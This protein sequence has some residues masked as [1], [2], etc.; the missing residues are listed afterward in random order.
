MKMKSHDFW[1][2]LNNTEVVVMPKSYIQT[3]GTTS[4][5]YHMVSELMDS[6]N[7]IR[8]REGTIKSQRPEI[9]TPT[10][11]E[12][13]M[14]EGFGDEAR[15]YMEWLRKHSQDVLILQYGFKIQKHDLNEHVVS[16]NVKEVLDVVKK[17]VLAKDDPFAGVILGVDDPWDVCLLKLMIDIIQKSAPMNFNDMKKRRLFDNVNGIPK[18]I[19]DEIE[20]GFRN[21]DRDPSKTNALMG[22]LKKHDV[23]EEYEDRFFELVRRRSG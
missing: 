12:D 13:A 2:A 7:R 23:F 20:T 22:L 5:H 18:Y 16:G 10:F 19:R 11:Q 4:L 1:F 21:A 8:V 14:L 15:Q 6:V 9:I 17:D 3:F